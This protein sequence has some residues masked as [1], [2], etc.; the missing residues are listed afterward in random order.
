MGVHEKRILWV[1]KRNG[2]GL[3]DGTRMNRARLW[4][5]KVIFA[6]PAATSEKAKHEIYFGRESDKELD[7][8]VDD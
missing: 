7:F 5:T 3:L 6:L 4:L 2:N 8:C 1:R